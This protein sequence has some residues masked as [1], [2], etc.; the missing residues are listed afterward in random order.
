MRRTRKITPRMRQLPGLKCVAY[1]ARFPEIVVMWSCT[2]FS[3]P[4]PNIARA[5]SD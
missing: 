3:S 5:T 2:G 4:R 1:N